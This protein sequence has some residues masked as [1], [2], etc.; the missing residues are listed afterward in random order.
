MHLNQRSDFVSSPKK[1]VGRIK[2]MG[3]ENVAVQGIGT[4]QRTFDDDS[5]MSHTFR[6]PGLL[7]VPKSPARLFSPQHWA[8]EQRDHSPKKNGTWQTTFHDNVVLVW[9]Q[10]AHRRTIPLDKSNVA[11]F[12]TTGG[13]KSFRMFQACYDAEQNDCDSL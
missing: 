4:I 7:Y 9:G 10:E 11:T 5:G 8:Q 3:S 6:I 12:T 2:G 13:S 1:V